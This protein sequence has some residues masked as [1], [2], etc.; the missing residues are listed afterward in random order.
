MT[1]RLKAA[2]ITDNDPG[3]I[4]DNTIG[5]VETNV[6]GLLGVALD[7]DITTPYDASTGH[8]HASLYAPVANGVTA[9][10]SH[11]HSGAVGDGG[12]T[13][14]HTK[15]ANIGTNTHAQLDTFVASKAAA[16]GLCDLDGSSLVP[17]ARIPAALTGKDADTL[18]TL[19]AASFEHVSN[20]DIAG[21]YAGLDVSA[22]VSPEHTSTA[23][24]E[25]QTAG[26]IVAFGDVCYL[27]SDGKL[28][29]A[30]ADAEATSGPVRLMMAGNSI[31]ANASGTFYDH[32]YAI[33]GSWTTGA[34]LYLSAATAGAITAT[35]P[36]TAGQVV[37]V[38]GY[39]NSATVVYFDP[40]KAWVVRT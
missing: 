39:A 21:G 8:N 40:D 20:K 12:G 14:D 25:T 6:A 31:A 23:V 7:V 35:P 37:R 11:A 38:V 30:K 29:K 13:V 2:R 24:A 19:H 5:E 3:S 10:N 28:W 4:I 1:Y 27:K 34:A 36:S 16:S 33:T 26:E 18:D 17:L 22:R 9:G 32:C 15:L